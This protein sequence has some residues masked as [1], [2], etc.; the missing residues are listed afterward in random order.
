M[1]RN[2]QDQVAVVTGA[3]RGIGLG[4]AQRLAAEGCRVV[5]WDLCTRSFDVA[6]AGF[7]AACLADVDVSDHR[8]VD[9]G[10]AATLV[11]VDHI[12]ILVNNAGISGPE[13]QVWDYPVEVWD[14]VLAIDLSGVFYCCRAVLPQ[15]RARRYGRIVNIAS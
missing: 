6:G 15:M 11:A 13:I 10:L 3:A 1:N 12:D 8:S 7:S 5:I 2:L 9:L 4:I 14:R